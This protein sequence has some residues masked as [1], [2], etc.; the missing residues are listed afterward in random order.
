[1][2]QKKEF[3]TH[4]F[5]NRSMYMCLRDAQLLTSGLR[6]SEVTPQRG[7]ASMLLLNEHHQVNLEIRRADKARKAHCGRLSLEV[8]LRH[9]F[10]ML[11]EDILLR[12]HSSE[13]DVQAQ[14]CMADPVP[15]ED[16]SASLQSTNLLFT[17]LQ[18][19]MVL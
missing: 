7:P 6:K 9:E 5:M 1:M 16:G 14:T 8:V 19:E 2:I 11:F 4:A 12:Q 15:A 10:G 17:C 18:M 13:I 3:H